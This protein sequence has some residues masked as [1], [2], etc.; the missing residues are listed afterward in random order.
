V[1]WAGGVAVVNRQVGDSAEPRGKKAVF[2][3]FQFPSMD[4]F[5][6]N[7]NSAQFGNQSSALPS[8]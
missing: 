4:G 1:G 8:L 6:G 7:L 3:W 2:P 5:G